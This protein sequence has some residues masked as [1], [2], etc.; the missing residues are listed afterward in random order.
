MTDFWAGKDPCWVIQ[1]CSPLVYAKCAAYLHREKPCW[2]HAV[3]R[4]EEVVKVRRDCPNCKVYR[5]YHLS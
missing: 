2:E 5:L 4:C 3:T 1:G